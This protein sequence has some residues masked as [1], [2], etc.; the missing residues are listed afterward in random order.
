MST[1]KTLGKAAKLTP[2][3][4]TVETPN[5]RQSN[6]TETNVLS[7]GTKTVEQTNNQPT[8]SEAKGA[9]T[10]N[11][12]LRQIPRKK[13]VRQERPKLREPKVKPRIILK[14]EI[15]SPNR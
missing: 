2:K 3:T 1:K 6:D 12:D 13:P 9:G 15:K 4:K 8:V 7:G 11:G 10:F 14:N 5:I